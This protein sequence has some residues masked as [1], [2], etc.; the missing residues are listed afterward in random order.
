MA[1]HKI[2]NAVQQKRDSLYHEQK[3]LCHFCKRKCIFGPFESGQRLPSRASTLDHLVDH[4]DDPREGNRLDVPCVMACFSCNQERS[5]ARVIELKNKK[6]FE[7]E[8]VESFPICLR[9]WGKGKRA[10]AT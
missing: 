3:G 5:K 6:S 9:L 10:E 1:K 4:V 7:Q 2:K 8:P